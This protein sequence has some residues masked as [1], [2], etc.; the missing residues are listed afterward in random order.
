MSRQWTRIACVGC[1]MGAFGFSAGAA[2]ITDNGVASVNDVTAGLVA[3]DLTGVAALTGSLTTNNSY[4]AN[5]TANTNAYTGRLTATVY[6]N[7]SAPSTALDTVLIVYEFVGNGPS[8]IDLFEFGINSGVSL[9]YG[10]LLAATHGT[11]ADLTTVGQA[12]PVV[13]L[14]Q[15]VGSNDTMLFNF[16]TTG[17][18]LGGPALTETFAWYVL[19]NPA[20]NG[21]NVAINF[22]DVEATDFGGA[23]FQTLAFVS[24]PGQPDLNVPAPGAA[25]LLGLGLAAGARRRR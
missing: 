7:V 23:Y 24:N 17:N 16:G 13:D 19:S 10:D 12:S 18:S 15:N 21:G 3:L 22:V 1:A 6:G 14:N 2:T 20:G 8:A 4:E 11:I 5:F 9:D 25:A